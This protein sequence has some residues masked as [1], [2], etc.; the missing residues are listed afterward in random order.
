LGER[1]RRGDISTP[2]PTRLDLARSYLPS[3]FDPIMPKVKGMSARSGGSPIAGSA[4]IGVGVSLQ[5]HPEELR[6]ARR[7]VEGGP[8]GT[9]KVHG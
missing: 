5:A 3:G 7:K 1:H 8:R 9:V 2:L 4:L 6:H